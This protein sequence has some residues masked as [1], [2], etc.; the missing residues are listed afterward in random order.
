MT[1]LFITSLLTVL[2]FYLL[3][4]TT[5]NPTKYGSCQSQCAFALQ[6]CFLAR[7]GAVFGAPSTTTDVIPAQMLCSAEYFGCEVECVDGFL[8]WM[9]GKLNVI[10]SS[11]EEV[12][13]LNVQA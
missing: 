13:G 8:G 9:G 12:D 11:R 3:H 6:S 5:A 2:T 1:P 10:A 4:A 7:T